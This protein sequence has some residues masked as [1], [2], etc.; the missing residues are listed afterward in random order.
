MYGLPVTVYMSWGWSTQLAQYP[1][2]MD[3]IAAKSM[4][5]SCLIVNI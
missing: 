3:K 4:K 1:N 5:V 2:F